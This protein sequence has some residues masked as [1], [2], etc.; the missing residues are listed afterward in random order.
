MAKARLISGMQVAME[1]AYQQGFD[2]GCKARSLD[3]RRGEKYERTVSN[4]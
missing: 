2:H 1:I 3:D 4:E